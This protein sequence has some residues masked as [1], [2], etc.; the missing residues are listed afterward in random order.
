MELGDRVLVVQRA[1]IGANPNKSGGHSNAAGGPGGPPPGLAKVDPNIIA[2][3][4]AAEG[5]PTRVLQM[6]NMVTPDELVDDGEFE[7]IVED[8]REECGKYGSVLDVKI[9]RPILTE[10]G[11]IDQKASEALEDLGKVF[12]M[13][14]TVDDT[15]KAMMSIA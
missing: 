9:P 15:K 12:V 6:L 2:A 7:E 13:Y 5:E 1:A 4:T 11:K 3:A 14:E 8:I 10:S